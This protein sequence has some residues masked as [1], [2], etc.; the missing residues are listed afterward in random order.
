[1][2]TIVIDL[3]GHAHGWELVGWYAPILGSLIALAWFFSPAQRH[4]R[5]LRAERDR[6]G[7]I[8]LAEQLDD[9]EHNGQA[10]EQHGAVR[11]VQP[12]VRRCGRLL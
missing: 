6:A 8:A 11:S 9:T 7:L 5:A 2:F 12:W 3:Q 10:A 1:V 4:R